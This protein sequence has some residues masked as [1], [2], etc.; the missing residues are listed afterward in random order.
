MIRVLDRGP[1]IPEDQLDAVMQPFF[2]LEVST[3]PRHRRHGSGSRHRP[4]TG[5]TVI[6]GSLTLRNREGGGLV[7][8]V[9][10]G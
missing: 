7:A 3:Q 1:G 4:A 6:G 8:E 9:R 5:A 10:I 2:R